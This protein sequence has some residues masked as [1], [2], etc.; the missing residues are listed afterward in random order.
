MGSTGMEE[1]TSI[2]DVA[3][4]AWKA[5]PTAANRKANDSVELDLSTMSAESPMVG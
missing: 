3:D 2:L 5:R 4:A 1:L